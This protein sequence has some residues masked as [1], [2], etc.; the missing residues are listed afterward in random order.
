MVDWSK[1]EE[2]EKL[3]NTVADTGSED[4]LVSLEPKPEYSTLDKLTGAATVFEEARLAG[5]T[6]DE[7]GAEAY[8]RSGKADQARSEEWEDSSWI[9]QKPLLA[10]E[11]T[12]SWAIGAGTKLAEGTTDLVKEVADDPL[13]AAKAPANIAMASL[14]NTV[15]WG[16]DALLY[17]V[18]KSADFYGWATGN[19]AVSNFNPYSEQTEASRYSGR[20]M[21]DFYSN[22]LGQGDATEYAKREGF[23]DLAGDFV[24]VAGIYTA[25]T[26]AIAKDSFMNSLVNKAGLPSKWSD[27]IFA[28]HELLKAQSSELR[29][30]IG[31]LATA[32]VNPTTTLDVV[33]QAAKSAKI[34]GKEA[35]KETIA[36]ELAVWGSHYKHDELYPEERTWKQDLAFN[37]GLPAALGVG[38]PMAAAATKTRQLFNRAADQ[39]AFYRN[40]ALKEILIRNGADAGT[41]EKVELQFGDKLGSYGLAGNQAADVAVAENYTIQMLREL[42]EQTLNKL[43]KQNFGNEVATLNDV[44]A[45]FDKEILAA[46]KRNSGALEELVKGVHNSEDKEFLKNAVINAQDNF[47]NVFTGTNSLTVAPRTDAA[48]R[49]ITGDRASKLAKLNKYLDSKNPRRTEKNILKAMEQKEKLETSGYQLID[50]EGNVYNPNNYH[51]PLTDSPEFRKSVVANQVPINVTGVKATSYSAKVDGSSFVKDDAFTLA[52]KVDGSVSISRPGIAERPIQYTD[53][54]AYDP[55]RHLLGRQLK[56][57]TEVAEYDKAGK[58]ILKADKL[59]QK[60][61]APMHVDLAKADMTQ[62]AYLKAAYDSLGE[63]RFFKLFSIPENQLTSIKK[64]AQRN[65]GTAQD[66]VSEGLEKLW[67]HKTKMFFNN[68]ERSAAAKGSLWE[69][70]PFTDVSLF[71]E[72]TGRWIEPEFLASKDVRQLLAEQA[73]SKL[74]VNS[75]FFRKPQKYVLQ[76]TNSLGALTDE[77]NNDIFN[78]LAATKEFRTSTLAKSEGTLVGDVARMTMAKPMYANGYMSSPNSIAFSTDIGGKL[79]RYVMTQEG[80]TEGNLALNSVIAYANE[81][82]LFID[83][84][85]GKYMKPLVEQT[86]TWIKDKSAVTDFSKFRYQ[87]QSGWNLADAEPVLLKDGRYGFKLDSDKLAINE[88]IAERQAKNTNG[89]F[90]FDQDQ[91]EYYDKELDEAFTL[92]PDP[93]TGQALTVDKRVADLLYKAHSLNGSIWEGNQAINQSLGRQGGKFRNYWMPPKD[94]SS[95]EIRIVG[96][97]ENGRFVPDIYVSGNT[98]EQAERAAKREMALAGWDKKREYSI[99]TTKEVGL[100]KEF[101][102]EDINVNGFRWVD[103][104]DSWQQEFSS[105]AGTGV[106]TSVGAIIDTG[107]GA[108]REWLESVNHNLQTQARRTRMALFSDEINQ[109][110]SMLAGKSYGDAG[111]N[112]LNDYIANLIGSKWNPKES[113][114]SVYKAFDKLVEQGA[115]AIDNWRNLSKY[116]RMAEAQRIADG[117]MRTTSHL[118]ESG[119]E[120]KRLYNFNGEIFDQAN[121]AMRMISKTKPL[122][123]KELIGAFNKVATWGLLMTANF[124]YAAMNLVSLPAVMPMMLKGL[125]RQPGE[126]ARS[127]QARIGAWGKVA[128]D[129]KTVFPDMIGAATET[130]NYYGHNKKEW[131]SLMSDF[132]EAGMLSTKAGLLSEAFI[133]PVGSLMSKGGRKMADYVSRFG[134]KSEE[135]SRAIPMAMGYRLG[136]KIGLNHMEAMSMGRKF[137]DKIVGNYVASNRPAL[138]Q[139]GLG[140]LLGLFYTYNHNLIQDYVQ[141][142]LQGQKAA[143]ATGLATQAFM[144]GTTSIPGAD[145]VADLFIPLDSGKDLYGALREGGFDDT[146]ARAFIYGFPSAITGLDFSS[147]GTINPSVPGLATP[148]LVSLAGNLWDMTVESVNQ[149]AANTQTNGR[150]LIE[151]MQNYL[152]FTAARSSLALGMG[153][154]TDRQGRLVVTKDSVGPALW[155]GSNIMSMRTLDETMGRVAGQRYNNYVAHQNELK[156]RI[157]RNIQSGLRDK[158]RNPQEVIHQG[159]IDWIAAGGNPKDMKNFVKTAVTKYYSTTLEEKARGAMA[160]KYQTPSDREWAKTLYYLAFSG[161]DSDVTSGNPWD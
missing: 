97:E 138:L 126:S 154:K 109:A 139:D 93:V 130:L 124:G 153:Y 133:D 123:S 94:L 10:L 101:I 103:Y 148:P 17:G 47:V 75:Y 110:R 40:S 113:R 100:E 5:F 45:A 36:G 82:S 119:D 156:G 29:R 105:L 79:G 7:N 70:P 155:Y 122:H 125:S 129:G 111:F 8:V 39:S 50:S 60:M 38:L 25:G 147:K 87:S 21:A 23:Y 28:D 54:A 78:R 107:E 106:R 141:L 30:T 81:A 83:K 86:Q 116:D 143:V 18:E 57:L 61:V 53:S 92:L 52:T 159:V 73:S 12:T 26:K 135:I 157:R 132:E 31:Q 1:I 14:M 118:F 44:K 35:A 115:Q 58:P 65:D 48:L 62:V 90:V 33:K 96:H 127:W 16:K 64:A 32:G 42:K 137:G 41:L 120:V 149:L 158:T 84:T 145:Q 85:I 161:S 91:L 142:S 104:G 19:E 151:I 131:K 3:V 102:Q 55:A 67:N 98:V 152:P 13:L 95:S 160:K 134:I 11:N 128:K 37:I 27:A 43:E 20:E 34:A 4:E 114:T 89:R 76:E 15:D 117:R 88:Q 24:P 51:M 136:R 63:T 56:N 46:E 146:Q 49:E 6:P 77:I 150:T 2:E 68:R 72:F 121:E 144:F 22:L 112:E 69:F 74:D 59:I 71:E 80:R 108:V 9:G 66:V 99:K 140:S